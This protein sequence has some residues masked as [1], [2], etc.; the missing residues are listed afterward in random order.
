MP[1]KLAGSKPASMKNNRSNNQQASVKSKNKT[2][3]HTGKA[4]EK[5]ASI[6]KHAKIIGSLGGR[7]KK[8]YNPYASV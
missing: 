7:P 2:S 3:K 6:S 5:P 4:Y 1:Q 8:E